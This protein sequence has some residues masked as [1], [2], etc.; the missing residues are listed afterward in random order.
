MPEFVVARYRASRRA[1][2]TYYDYDPT[3]ERCDAWCVRMRGDLRT[4]LT[5]PTS[6]CW[7]RADVCS[8]H[9]ACD[10]VALTF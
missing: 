9:S 4:R 3:T 8:V 2:L 6:R 7:C 1:A 5:N 10:R